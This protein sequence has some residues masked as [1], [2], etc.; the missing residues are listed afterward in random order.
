[1]MNLLRKSVSLSALLVAALLPSQM[2]DALPRPPA[3]LAEPVVAKN[4]GFNNSERASHVSALKAWQIAKPR[5][6]VVV[7]V[8][9]TGIDPTHPLIKNNLWRDKT[10]NEYGYDFVLKRRNPGDPHGHGTHVAGLVLAMAN[11]AGAVRNARIRIMP[12]RYYSENSTSAQHLSNTVRA[13]NY[14][15]DHGAK[16]IN[17]SGEG[18]GFNPEEF[19]A[20]RRAEAKGVLF[21]TAAGNQSQDNDSS[22]SPCY[23]GSYNL[24][25]ILTVA[26][27]NIHNNL[28]P[29]SNWGR[30]SVHVAAPGENILS[31]LP[32]RV[33]H[34]GYGYNSGTSQATAIVS[35]LA[36]LLLAENPNL[37]PRELKA[38]LMKSAD[39]LPGLK[40]KL[41]SGGRI[42][43]FAALELAQHARD[44]RSRVVARTSAGPAEPILAPASAALNK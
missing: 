22:E 17:Y 36:A 15:V 33:A 14:A 28:I 7:A 13:I 8:I 44:S 27:T 37:S 1:M 19:R 24:G 39:A 26:A 43:A 10:S 34:S 38:I 20:I 31:S 3:S 30:K 40:G 9:D 29:S 4:W 2:A 25:N 21:V 5:H 23:P 42:N 35:G 6:E 12:V 11:G 41:V 18:V 16:I 32:K